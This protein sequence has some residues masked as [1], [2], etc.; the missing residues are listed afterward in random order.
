MIAELHGKSTGSTGGWGG[1]MH[2]ADESCGFM[3]ASPGVG[4]TV[5]MAIGS[6]MAF[7]MD[8]SGRVAVAFFGDSAVETGQFWEAAN[9]AS[10][11]KLPM[12]FICENNQYAT[13]THISQRQPDNKIYERVSTFMWSECVKDSDINQVYNAAKLCRGM[14]PGF[15]EIETYRYREHVGPDYD[16]D[17]GYRTE[18]EVRDHMAEDPLPVVRNLLEDDQAEAIE[19]EVMHRVSVAFQQAEQDPWPEPFNEI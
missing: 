18:T 4:D 2:L 15:L 1:S 9:F 8:G 13:A 11:H 5:S 19:Q 6:A 17:F 3:G 10:L 14:A 16:W 12:M 7:K